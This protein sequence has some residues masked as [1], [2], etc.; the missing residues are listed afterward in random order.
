MRDNDDEALDDEEEA[1]ILK[2]DGSGAAEAG[3]GG[4][5]TIGLRGEA[6]I[7]RNVLAEDTLDDSLVAL[8]ASLEVGKGGSESGRSL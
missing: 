8:N 2:L 5:G 6:E 7:G 3:G 1:V 4:R